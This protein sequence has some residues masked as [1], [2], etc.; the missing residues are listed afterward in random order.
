MLSCNIQRIK[1]VQHQSIID[2]PTKPSIMSHRLTKIKPYFTFSIVIYK[3]THKHRQPLH[4]HITKM[5][6][7]FNKCSN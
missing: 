4:E 6:I 5:H 3:S 7:S 2:E 1:A